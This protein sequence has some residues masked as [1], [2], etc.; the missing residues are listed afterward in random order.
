M[1]IEPVYRGAKG[2]QTMVLATV[3]VTVEG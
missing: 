1:S 2:W 3:R